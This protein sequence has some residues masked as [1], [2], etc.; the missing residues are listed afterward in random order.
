MFR[1]QCLR[2]TL[3]I[4]ALCCRSSS[5]SSYNIIIPCNFFLLLTRT[6]SS[7]LSHHLRIHIWPGLWHQWKEFCQYVF[8]Q[9]TAVFE[10]K[11]QIGPIGSMQSNRYCVQKK[12]LFFWILCLLACF[13]QCVM[14]PTV[15]PSCIATF[16]S[17]TCDSLHPLHGAYT[18]SIS[19]NT[20]T[21]L[22]LSYQ[23]WSESESETL[24]ARK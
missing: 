13:F 6:H 2:S 20:F 21:R 23:I 10:P 5:I 16:P 8:I 18:I 17:C 9:K 7:T 22:C 4:M 12:R 19:L 15:Y 11:Y 3:L 24:N 1:L 14:F